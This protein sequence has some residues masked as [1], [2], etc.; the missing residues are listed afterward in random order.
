MVTKILHRTAIVCRGQVCLT[1]AVLLSIGFGCST[2]G[3]DKIGR[4]S[5]PMNRLDELWDFQDPAASEQRF[6]AF[7]ESSP[8]AAF[9]AEV[10]TQIA[11]AQG[12]QNAFD[13]A[14]ATLDEA[15]ALMPED[16]PVVRI[17][18][19]LE[20]GRVLNSSDKPTESR[21]YFVDALALAEDTGEDYYAVDAAHMLG[22]VDLPSEQ[23]A[24]SERALETARKSKDPRAQ[25]WLGPLYNNLGW[26]YHDTGNYDK[27]LGLF[28]GALAW[29]REH[30]NAQQI[31]I[32]RWSVAR[33]LRSLARVEEALAMQEV[34]LKDLE[35][36]GETD[37]YV[38]EELAECLAALGRDD[39]AAE[40][41]ALAYREL[42]QDAWLM[43]SEPA[44]VERLKAM[45]ENA[46]EQRR[47]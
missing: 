2:A 21:P 5:I 38:Y 43:K 33:A 42:S 20:R 46:G 1:A 45:S 37:G 13:E 7:M 22:I 28:E 11:R 27:A 23:I 36:A 40:Y 9:R 31:R 26:S 32:A 30:G 3:D 25:R 4:K 10:L 6:R 12:L 19:L 35:A 15:E 29:Y 24:W 14:S 34:L 44:R 41:F 8:D 16:A 18:L 17:R 47:E 39:E